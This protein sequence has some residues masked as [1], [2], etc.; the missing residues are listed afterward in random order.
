[1]I[2]N[3]SII[4]HINSP[5]SVNSFPTPKPVLADELTDEE[6]NVIRKSNR[7]EGVMDE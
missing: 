4:C 2:R 5:P 1:M 3:Q 6:L 7:R